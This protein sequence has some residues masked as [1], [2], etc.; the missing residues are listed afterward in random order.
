[1][2]RRDGAFLERCSGK[3]G[4]RFSKADGVETRRVVLTGSGPLRL[5]RSLRIIEIMEEIKQA[6]KEPLP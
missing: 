4:Q 2:D 6:L 3:Y 5:G 1:M